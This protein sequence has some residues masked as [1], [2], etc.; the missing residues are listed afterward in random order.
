MVCS[1]LTIKRQRSAASNT[2]RLTSSALSW[3]AWPVS[4]L[5]CWGW[6]FSYRPCKLL[7]YTH[8]VGNLPRVA[9]FVIV[10]VWSQAMPAVVGVANLGIKLGNVFFSGIPR[11]KTSAPWKKRMED[12]VCG[13]TV[14]WTLNLVIRFDSMKYAP[15]MCVFPVYYHSFISQF[16]CSITDFSQRNSTSSKS[17]SSFSSSSSF[18]SQRR[19]TSSCSNQMMM[20]MVMMMLLWWWWW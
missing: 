13:Q 12:R 15:I 14:T 18:M 3:G 6:Q 9:Y 7:Q 4:R 19:T 20:M 16:W 2:C 5:W 11:P 17:S 8:R 10:I 1:M